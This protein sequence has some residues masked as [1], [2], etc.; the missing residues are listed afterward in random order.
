MSPRADGVGRGEQAEPGV[1]PDDAV[2][3][4]QGQLA[5]RLQH[6]LDHEHHVRA[7]GVVFVEHQR[8]RPLDRPGQ[9]AFAEFG[10]LLAVLQDDGV[11]AHQVD[12]RHVAVEV[13]PHQRPVQPC[14]HLLDV[15]RLAGAVE[16]LDHH[17]AVVGE[18]GQQGARRLGVELVALVEV[19]HVRVARGE[20][21]R[22]HVEV[23]AERLARVDLVVGDQ[24]EQLVFLGVKS[25]HG[26]LRLQACRDGSKQVFHGGRC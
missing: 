23:D 9:H 21:G 15:R 1:R 12:P 7:A 16:A 3:V 10:D 6:A 4:E 2:L 18:A 5:L 20:G 22:L 13:H 19:R 24:R 26:G 8:D 17:A 25:G 14:G 11:L